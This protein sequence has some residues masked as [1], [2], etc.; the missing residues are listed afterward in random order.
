VFRYECPTAI[1]TVNVL[2]LVA[3]NVQIT[4]K[5]PTV[6]SVRGQSEATEINA[7]GPKRTD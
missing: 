2:D 6:T 1:C 5:D 3:R 7:S 4:A